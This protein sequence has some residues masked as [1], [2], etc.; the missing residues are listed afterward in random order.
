[1]LETKPSVAHGV[2]PSAISAVYC[3]LFLEIIIYFLLGIHIFP[4]AAIF[5]LAFL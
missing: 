3:R 1:M 4:T 5:S 2:F